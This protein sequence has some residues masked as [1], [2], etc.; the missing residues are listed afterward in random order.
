MS[1]IT[2]VFEDLASGRPIKKPVKSNLLKARKDANEKA[3]AS[4]FMKLSPEERRKE[5]KRL[6]ESSSWV[7]QTA[8]T[9]NDHADHKHPKVQKHIKKAEKAYNDKD[10]EG[11]HHHTTRAADHAHSL[12]K[13]EATAKDVL[14]KRYASDHPDDN[15]HHTKRIK[16]HAGMKTYKMHPGAKTTDGGEWSKKGKM[17]AL[18]KQHKRRPEQYGITE[19]YSDSKK[20]KYELYSDKNDHHKAHDEI[21]K[22]VTHKSGNPKHMNAAMKKHAKHGASD[23]ASREAI[24]GHFMKHHAD[25]NCVL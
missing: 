3:L 6:G 1:R 10:M 18:K 25:K 8:D 23:T 7:Q 2:K 11:F 22:A 20:N 16:D 19:D 9:W 13:N 17:A 21:H 4:G 15:P 14:K 12:K 24:V 5:S